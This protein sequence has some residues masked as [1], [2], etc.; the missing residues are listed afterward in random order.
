M[1]ARLSDV[2]AGRIRLMDAA[3]IDMQVL[4]HV[5]PGVQI[6]S[7]ADAE[8]AVAV[9]REVNDWLA[10]AIAAHPRRLT[11]FAML[12]TQS[13]G[14]T[15]GWH[16]WTRLTRYCGSKLASRTRR[17][18]TTCNPDGFSQQ[19]G[20]RADGHRVLLSPP[21]PTAATPRARAG[22]HLPLMYLPE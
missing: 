7:D 16:P 12:P 10:E 6:L 22:S 13:P 9:S 4:T 11:G 17:S 15:S 14:A 5:Q 3:G 20:A 2:G 18:E 21:S 19:C 8:L 1:N